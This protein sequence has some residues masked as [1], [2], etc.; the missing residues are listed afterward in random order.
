MDILIF[1]LENQN[2]EFFRSK[3]VKYDDFFYSKK[4]LYLDSKIWTLRNAKGFWKDNEISNNSANY[5]II[6]FQKPNLPET[7]HKDGNYGVVEFTT[8][9][10][11]LDQES[12]ECLSN[13]IDPYWDLVEE[14]EI[15]G[16]SG[17]II[18]NDSI[19]FSAG[20]NL[21][22]LMNF[23]KDSEWLKGNPIKSS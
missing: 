17:L 6:E 2:I 15:S 9:A 20:V 8:K 5:H 22:Y 12:I 21:N 1:L 23:A 16:W 13:S 18:I 14:E 10:N 11:T 7:F 3:L 19:Q 4:Q